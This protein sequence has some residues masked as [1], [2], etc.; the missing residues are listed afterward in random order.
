MKLREQEEQGCKG[1]TS[2]P[3]YRLQLN[4]ERGLLVYV[5]NFWLLS[6]ADDEFPEATGPTVVRS[7]VV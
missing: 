4:V 5:K 2:H 1:M 7:R 6:S 3:L